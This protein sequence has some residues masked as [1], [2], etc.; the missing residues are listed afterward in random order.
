MKK[1][2][3]TAT[4][5]AIKR[6]EK[7]RD[8][9]SVMLRDIWHFD[10]IGE[11]ETL[12]S[13]EGMEVQGIYT[14]GAPII[15]KWEGNT[16]TIPTEEI[17]NEVWDLILKPNIEAW[18]KEQAVKE[19]ERQRLEAEYK[20]KQELRRQNKEAKAKNTPLTRL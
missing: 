13:D 11:S 6:G 5:R 9:L 15:I 14:I 1:R 7:I 17:T 3:I 18:D 20:R 8:E 16:T 12:I 2:T 19:K 4:T 10:Y